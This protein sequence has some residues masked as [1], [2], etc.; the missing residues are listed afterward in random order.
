[1]SDH[2]LTLDSFLS[3]L[4]EDPVAAIRGSNVQE[5]L[6]RF[7]VAGALP[8]LMPA[9]LDAVGPSPFSRV[10]RR[11]WGHAW[12]MARP[13]LADA[14]RDAALGSLDTK[15]GRALRA[16]MSPPQALFYL[17]SQL[18]RLGGN[19]D[20]WASAFGHWARQTPNPNEVINRPLGWFTSVLLWY[21]HERPS[22]IAVV[23]RQGVALDLELPIQRWQGSHAGY[24]TG[25]PH[26]LNDRQARPDGPA[27]TLLSVAVEQATG[28]SRHAGSW[29][30]TAIGLIELGARLDAPAWTDP[31]STVGDAL[32][33]W[34]D[35]RPAG[36]AWARWEDQKVQALVEMG[37]RAPL[38]WMAGEE[39]GSAGG[40]RAPR[41]R[42]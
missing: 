23:L 26:D 35:A 13:D 20:S 29:A 41:S 4:R 22:L 27:W 2:V 14:W 12:A 37:Q 40:T 15:A 18:W 25:V 38:L 3:A 5:H 10:A 16:D 31:H 19:D 6:G 36:M 42:L 32:F 33:R 39:A 24:L 9:L 34:A 30:H 28:T 11:A 17:S 7:G 1:M 21:L 8:V